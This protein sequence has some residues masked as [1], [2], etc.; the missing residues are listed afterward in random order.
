MKGGFDTIHEEGPT[1]MQNLDMKS[2]KP[3]DFGYGSSNPHF[4]DFLTQKPSIWADL[5]RNIL[6]VGKL[7]PLHIDSNRETKLKKFI[8]A[9]KEEKQFRKVKRKKQIGAKVGFID[10][11]EGFRDNFFILLDY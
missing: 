4:L 5:Y 10:A 11:V 1:K 7:P 9:C 3:S 8:R 6:P 2:I